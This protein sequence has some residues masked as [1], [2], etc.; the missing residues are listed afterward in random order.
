LLVNG[1]C[2]ILRLQQQGNEKA[3]NISLV[4]TQRTAPHSLQLAKNIKLWR[5]FIK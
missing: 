5:H 3:F 2:I 4:R 1:V